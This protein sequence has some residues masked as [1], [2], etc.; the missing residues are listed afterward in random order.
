MKQFIIPAAFLAVVLLGGI[1]GRQLLLGG[2]Q[3]VHLSAAPPL[4]G[5][6]AQNLSGNTK[7]TV[8]VEG[9]DFK[10]RNLRYFSNNNWVVLEAEPIQDKFNLSFIVLEKVG[11]SYEVVLG[12][13]S[14]FDTSYLLSVPADVASYLQAKGVVYDTVE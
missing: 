6:V 7:R 11:G 3:V 5:L 14:A 10:L 9:K 13:G 2:S 12:P 1:L 4:A 8:A